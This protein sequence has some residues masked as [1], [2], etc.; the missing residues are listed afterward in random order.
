M[1]VFTK[2][3]GFF[4]KLVGIK[5]KIKRVYGHKA[6]KPDV[7]DFKFKAPVAVPVPS[8][9]DLS[10]SFTPC[11]DQGQLGSCTANAIAAAIE[12][13]QIKENKAFDFMPSRLFIY[14]NERAMEGTINEDSG[15]AIRDGV[16]AVNVNGV[17]KEALCP[18]IESAFTQKPSPQAYAEALLHK[19]VQYASLNN[20][21]INDL[22]ACLAGG[23]PFVFGF[24][25]YSSFE[26]NA[27]ARTGI[28]PMPKSYEQ[29]LGGHA[30][31]CVGYDDAKKAFLVRNSWGTGWGLKGYFWM[32]YAYMTSNKVSD[33]WTIKSITSNAG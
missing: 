27:V 19:S 4:K 31:I 3:V 12:F 9:V 28:M 11:Y 10:P 25:V 33:C 32:P 8:K 22:K 21:Q 16:K 20:M 6:D 7:R 30:V 17:C 5:P 26:S 23:F 15:A 29:N 2:L 24:Q 13:D 18:Y 14:Y 1:S